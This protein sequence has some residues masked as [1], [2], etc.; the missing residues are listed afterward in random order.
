MIA[1][2]A[3]YVLNTRERDHF[4]FVKKSG[5]VGRISIDTYDSSIESSDKLQLVEKKVVDN[6]TILFIKVK[7]DPSMVVVIH[8]NKD[9]VRIIGDDVML[10]EDMVRV[11]SVTK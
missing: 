6:L 1:L 2:P 7:W 8:D 3:E 9:G 4:S 11:C 10:W 5:G